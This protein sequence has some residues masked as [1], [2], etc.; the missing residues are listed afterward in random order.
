MDRNVE[1]DRKNL[2]LLEA[3]GWRVLV[4]WECQL[5]DMEAV[6]IQIGDFLGEK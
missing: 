3:A 6:R 1:R 2:A 5:R 4:I